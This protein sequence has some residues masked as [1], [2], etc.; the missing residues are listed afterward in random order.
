MEDQI[1]IYDTVRGNQ[2]L[3]Y[4][5][6]YNTTNSTKMKKNSNHWTNIFTWKKKAKQTQN[7]IINYPFMPNQKFSSMS[8]ATGVAYSF[9]PPPGRVLP[10]PPQPALN[11]YATPDM[12]YVT[13]TTT[14]TTTIHASMRH[15]PTNRHI[16]NRNSLFYSPWEALHDHS[17]QHMANECTCQMAEPPA[18]VDTYCSK[19]EMQKS[20]R[21]L[22]SNTVAMIA[23]TEEPIYES[24]RLSRMDLYSVEEENSCQ[25]KAIDLR[26]K[27]SDSLL[28]IKKKTQPSNGLKSC[29]S[30]TTLSS[31]PFTLKSRSKDPSSATVNERFLRFFKKSS[32][33]PYNSIASRK[34]I[35][36]C[37]VSAYDL[38]KQNLELQIYE[39]DDSLSDNAI[40]N[41]TQVVGNAFKSNRKSFTAD[42]H[43]DESNIKSNMISEGR[44]PVVA[45]SVRI[46][47]YGMS[48]APPAPKYTKSNQNK[49]A[50]KIYSHLDSNGETPST[51]SWSGG[52][53]N[54]SIILPE[55]D[56]DS[57]D[58]TDYD[59][60]GT[61]NTKLGNNGSK[62]AHLKVSYSP[63]LDIEDITIEDVNKQIDEI[64]EKSGER[65]LNYQ[66]KY[67][68]NRI[69]NNESD[70]NQ[71]LNDHKMRAQPPLLVTTTTNEPPSPPP[72]PPVLP[73]ALP[74]LAI[75]K[76]GVQSKCN[77]STTNVSYQC[78]LK[79]K[80][81]SG[82]KSI[83]KKSRTNTQL[84]KDQSLSKSE[85]DLNKGV[86]NASS[87]SG[88][89]TDSCDYLRTFKEF[90]E[91]RLRPM[92]RH[93]KHV[94]FKSQSHDRLLINEISAQT[95]PEVEESDE[96]IYDDVRLPG[97]ATTG[98]SSDD[99][100]ISTSGS[101]GQQTINDNTND[102]NHKSQ[103]L[104][105]MSKSITS[106]NRII[107][108]VTNDNCITN[109][110]PMGTTSVSRRTGGPVEF[111]EFD[112]SMCSLF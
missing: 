32:L 11:T 91:S 67:L 60:Y 18:M 55:P 51:S 69:N 94:H 83:L 74:I 92:G 38:I 66:N 96:P 9:A 97:V 23:S 36:E 95:I 22:P 77:S 86:K 10:P 12:N 90:K 80:L 48:F 73:P 59:S 100:S 4:N 81:N 7:S 31:S 30:S 75:N 84:T 28:D 35:L 88:S 1:K 56:Y 78:E 44:H 85:T 105:A 33:D 65:E 34:S 24:R 82:V 72:E 42:S 63:P 14:T 109:D 89:S 19:K 106:D 16:Q 79:D 93:R 15:N 26:S 37:D 46:G 43:L 57:D 3:Y 99:D 103:Q 17:A 41:E 61:N 54:D 52:S 53:S 111:A 107:K 50:L 64:Y 25:Q 8:A 71:K 68:N 2:L 20:L 104:N 39:D 21:G 45:N 29:R 6:G 49:S 5:S 62:F 102:C 13:A 76:S 108:S 101:S 112:P 47:G 70:I 98:S 27:S 40:E 110:I 87:T 58:A